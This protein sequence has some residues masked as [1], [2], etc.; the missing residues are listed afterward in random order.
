VCLLPL[1]NISV[2]SGGWQNRNTHRKPAQV[3]D[4]RQ[5]RLFRVQLAVWLTDTFTTSDIAQIY[6]K[7]AWRQIEL[8]ANFCDVCQLLTLA[9]SGYSGFLL[10]QLNWLPGYNGHIDDKYPKPY[11]HPWIMLT[12][13]TMYDVLCFQTSQKFAWSSIWRHAFLS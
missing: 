13:K 11:I 6:D 3:T 12:R 7:N 4:K 2:L 8:H 1:A 5:Q 10:N 9:F